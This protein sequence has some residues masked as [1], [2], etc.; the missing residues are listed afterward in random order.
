MKASIAGILMEL[1]KIKAE[2]RALRDLIINTTGKTE[3]ER[4]KL[5]AYWGAQYESYIRALG[6][7]EGC[8]KLLRQCI[9]STGLNTPESR[10]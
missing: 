4:S 3:A 10:P 5:M 2:G 9:E 7:A 6:G 1:A 8:E